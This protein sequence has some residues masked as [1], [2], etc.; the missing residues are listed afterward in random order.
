[1]GFFVFCILN[2]FLKYSVTFFDYINSLITTHKH[3]SVLTSPNRITDNLFLYNSHVNFSCS[4]I[5]FLSKTLFSFGE[6]IN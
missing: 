4:K 1:M 3:I 6:K 2:Y 5:G